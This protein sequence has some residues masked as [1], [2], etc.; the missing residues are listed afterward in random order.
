MK[1]KYRT[2]PILSPYI[3]KTYSIY[4]E[5]DKFIVKTLK[6]YLQNYSFKN[7]NLIDVG[8]GNALLLYRIKKQF[9][10]LHLKGVD[11]EKKFISVAKKFSG[12]SGVEFEIN[13]IYKI[14]KKYDVVICSSTFQI[15]ED[16][17]KP[18]N[19]LISL[20]NSKGII[21][22]DGLFNT[23][24]VETRLIYC[25]NSNKVAKN[26]WRK[27]WNQHSIKTISNFLKSKKINTFKFYDL[28]MNKNIK[29]NKKIHINQFTFRN[30][31]NYNLITNGTNMI[32][33]RKLLVIKL[34]K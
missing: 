2:I 23:Y 14:K 34:N 22:I 10:N 1:A 30:K 9:P 27:D 15:F 26:L 32:L 8:C 20:A 4:K 11:R 25:D 28:L 18:L 24:D 21:F 3:K 17:K 12:L 13:D 5:K 7:N 31:Q 16:Y 29:K 6:K 33:N 19:K